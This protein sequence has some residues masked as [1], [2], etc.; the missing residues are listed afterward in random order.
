[1]M[2][3]LDFDAPSPKFSIVI[4]TYNRNHLLNP[5]LTQL[6][7]FAEQGVEVIV[8]DNC[9]D[10]PASEVTCRLPWVRNIRAPRNLGAA[11][12]NL[13][14]ETASGEIIICL[15]DDIAELKSDSLRSLEVAFSDM[16]VAAANFKVLEQRTGEVTN[17]VHHRQ[18]ELY[19]DTEFDTYEITEG[20][21]AFRRSAL[22]LVGGYPESF[23]L[24]HEGP[25]LAFR[26]INHG[27]RV[28]YLPTV[29]V[30]HSFE[31]AGRTSWRN[32]YFDTRNTFWLAA[33]NLPVVYGLKVVLRQSLGML[34]FSIRDGYL[35]W[36]IRGIW[37][38]ITGLRSAWSHRQVL[39]GN[40]YLRVRSID[41]FR[42]SA[43]YSIKRR[44]L[45][46]NLRL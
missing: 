43:C 16:D 32:Y 18:V 35:R 26:L 2:N 30:V 33:R 34:V 3:A 4:L 7:S 28:I 40:A 13:G 46:Q 23:F 25:D 9:S 8:V 12:R 5:L 10:Q 19:A 20:A 21:V 42:P 37:D 17:W 39:S 29:S 11:G 36:W 38:G 15:D 6:E 24:S 31:Q 27:L 44:V 14:F 41:R 22:E 45:Q 1:M